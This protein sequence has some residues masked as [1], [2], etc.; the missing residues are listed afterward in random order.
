MN[1]K[2]ERH[3]LGPGELLTMYRDMVRIREFEESCPKLYSQ[4]NTA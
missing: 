4:G 3:L 1:A 2:K